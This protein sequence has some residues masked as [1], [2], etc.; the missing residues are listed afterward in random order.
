MEAMD[1][2]YNKSKIAESNPDRILLAAPGVTYSLA[3]RKSSKYDGMFT[4]T[5]EG[6]IKAVKILD[7]IDLDGIR[8]LERIDYTEGMTVLH[9]SDGLIARY[10]LVS[11]DD[12]EFKSPC[13]VVDYNEPVSGTL[14]LDIRY[15]YDNEPFDKNYSVAEK[16]ISRGR[17]SKYC[18]EKLFTINYEKKNRDPAFS[19]YDLKAKCE[20]MVQSNSKEMLAKEE[21]EWVKK[22]NEHDLDRKD[23]PFEAYYFKP[24]S[25]HK[26]SRLIISE[27]NP[28]AFSTRYNQENYTAL[29]QN[30]EDRLFD[31]GIMINRKINPAE[32]EESSKTNIKIYSVPVKEAES[33]LYASIAQL[34]AAKICSKRKGSFRECDFV[35]GYPWFFQNWA[36]DSAISLKA[37]QILRKDSLLK[38]L[39]LSLLE[40]LIRDESSIKQETSIRSADALPL[41]FLRIK[42]A[43]YL[44]TDT[45]KEIIKKKLLKYLK[46]LEEQYLRDDLLYNRGLET[47]M[48]TGD[49]FREGFNIEI[50]ALY[51][52]MLE[53]AVILEKDNKR[54]SM[55]F[56]NLALGKNKVKEA[57]Y[58]V[59]EGVLYDN[60]DSEKNRTRHITNSIF[61]AH[62]FYPELLSVEEWEKSFDSALRVLTTESSL[63]LISSISKHSHL[64]RK[65]HSGINNESYHRGDSWYFVNNIAAMALFSVNSQKYSS[66]IN[67]IFKASVD[68]CLRQ[69]A[70]CYFSEISS[71]SKQESKGC[72]AQTWSASTFLELCGTLGLYE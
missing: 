61:L 17:K 10:R 29:V 23:L 36:R 41:T 21:N 28:A 62:Y 16:A 20:I 60:L 43:L 69:G 56:E 15:A 27:K 45:E 42:Q 33:S 68:D 70:L 7:S 65:I 44:F 9:F 18:S 4:Y 22:I 13:L 48:D 57:F 66:H 19:K 58:D 38:T 6:K 63:G 64:Y 1:C 5:N 25:F 3:L 8:T 2:Y 35:A 53:L 71:A 51:L 32:T 72:W 11:Y 14:L 40:N 49:N 37:M 47:W 26:I 46:G 24:L 59:K 39:L 30:I 67:A 50:N 31:K 52:S 54:E 12:S 34:R 55:L